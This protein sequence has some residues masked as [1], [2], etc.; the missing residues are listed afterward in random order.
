MATITGMKN[1]RKVN[2]IEEGDT[3]F[4]LGTKKRV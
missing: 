1:F 4:Y 2:F 3:L